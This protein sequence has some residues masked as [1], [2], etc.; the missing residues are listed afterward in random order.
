MSRRGKGAAMRTHGAASAP[1][2]LPDP[3]LASRGAH[4]RVKKADWDMER[5]GCTEVVPRAANPASSLPQSW[6][7]A[8]TDFSPGVRSCPLALLGGEKGP[9]RLTSS[10]SPMPPSVNSATSANRSTSENRHSP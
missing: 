3:G 1:F 10:P 4:R 2:A 5:R 7:C 8:P 6:A 9:I